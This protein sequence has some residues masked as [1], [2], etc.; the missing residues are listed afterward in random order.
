MAKQIGMSAKLNGTLGQGGES[1][2]QDLRLCQNI[3]KWLKQPKYTIWLI[4]CEE[5]MHPLMIPEKFLLLAIWHINSLM[6][7]LKVLFSQG[8]LA[9]YTL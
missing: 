9:F 1:S 4:L 8:A 7:F 5:V 2:P 6:V 3:L